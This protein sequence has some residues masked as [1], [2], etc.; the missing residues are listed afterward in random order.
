M[1][2]P[3]TL[4][5]LAL[6]APLMSSAA[7]PAKDATAITLQSNQQWLQ[8]LPFADRGDFG[9]AQRGLIERYE[10]VV[11]NAHGKT[12]WDLNQYAFLNQTNAPGT[13]N[14]SLWRQSQLNMNHGRRRRRCVR[15]PRSALR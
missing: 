1:R 12:V 10:G 3:P 6:L 11:S 2:F 5:S 8:R 4:L 7:T 15:P 13:V 9:A 14:P